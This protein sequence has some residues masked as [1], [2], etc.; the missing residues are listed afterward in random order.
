MAAAFGG[1]I[2]YFAYI[3]PQNCCILT[4]CSQTLTATTISPCPHHFGMGMLNVARIGRWRSSKAESDPVRRHGCQRIH[5]FVLIASV[6]GRLE[7]I[8]FARNL[9]CCPNHPVSNTNVSRKP[10]HSSRIASCPLSRVTHAQLSPVLQHSSES[11][12]NSITSRQQDTRRR[13]TID[14]TIY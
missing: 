4:H 1:S 2:S 10:E 11:Q 14:K 9:P 3:S 12:S 13:H 8:E 7:V 5:R 6:C